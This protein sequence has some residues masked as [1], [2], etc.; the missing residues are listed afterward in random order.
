[1][2]SSMRMT[3]SG[4]NV[5]GSNFAFEFEKAV[6]DEAQKAIRKKLERVKYPVHGQNAH[7]AS[8]ER[9]SSQ[10]N[11]KIEGYCESLAEA[12]KKAME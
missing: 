9:R 11:F 8:F 12:V 6:K 10:W 2:L 3:M 5:A 7:V 1:M 4:R